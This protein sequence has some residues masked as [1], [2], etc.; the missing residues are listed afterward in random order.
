LYTPISLLSLTTSAALSFHGFAYAEY[1]LMTS[2]TSWILSISLLVLFTGA[3]FI[4]FSQLFSD[5]LRIL[6]DI[7]APGLE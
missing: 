7:C 2:L 6:K 4:F 3:D 5:Y 1:N